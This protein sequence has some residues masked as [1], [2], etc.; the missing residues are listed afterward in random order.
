[1]TMLTSG[2]TSLL[3]IVLFQIEKHKSDRIVLS[4]VRAKL[5]VWLVHS[6]STLAKL[7]AHFG[8]GSLRIMLHFVLHKSL[9]GIIHTINF[10]EDKLHQ[11]RHHNKVIA[12]AVTEARQEGGHLSQIAAH[13]E[14]T[15]LSD[16]EKADLKHRSLNQT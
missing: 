14:T 3:L 10:V 1:M 6:E 9:N 12:K 2:V 16:K 13:K 15:A 5:D 11:L 7:S 8:T 4:G